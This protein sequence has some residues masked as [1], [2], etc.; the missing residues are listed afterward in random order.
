MIFGAYPDSLAP[1]AEPDQVERPTHADQQA[2]EG[3]K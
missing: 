1:E 2:N 3:E